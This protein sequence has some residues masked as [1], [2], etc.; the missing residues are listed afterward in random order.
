MLETDCLL[1]SSAEQ[2]KAERLDN[3]LKHAIELSPA[4]VAAAAAADCRHSPLLIISGSSGRSIDLELRRRQFTSRPVS[5]LSFL[6]FSL[7][8]GAAGDG[9]SL[10]RGRREREMAFAYGVRAANK[11]CHSPLRGSSASMR[12]AHDDDDDEFQ[13]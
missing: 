6:S 10:V 12:L 5:A 3:K 4:V 9:K 2:S 1:L 11:L 7:S 13:V 8:V